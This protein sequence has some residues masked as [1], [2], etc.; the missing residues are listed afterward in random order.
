[1]TTQAHEHVPPP[2]LSLPEELLLMLLNEESGYF[3]QVPGWNL[4]CTFI[5]AVLAELSFR[6]RID[7]DLESLFVLDDTPTGIDTLDPILAEIADEPKRRSTEY[8]I[9]RL[10]ARAEPIIDL[11]LSEL[12]E[13][14]YLRHHEGEFWTRSR[15]V[16][17]A[18]A[19][20]GDGTSGDIVD[21]R[22]QMIILSDAIPEPRDVITIALLN[23][24][25]VLPFIVSFDDDTQQRIE[26]ICE[27]DVIGRSITSAVGSNIARPRVHSALTKNIPRLP[28]RKLLL[29]RY[30][31]SGNIAA[32]FADLASCYGP[33][34]EFRPPLSRQSYVFLAGPE[35][36]RWVHRRGRLFLRSKDYLAKVEAAH[37]TART[38]H[39][40]DGADHFR[41]RSGLRPSH[42]PDTFL[43]RLDEMSSIAHGELSSWSVGDV[44]PAKYAFQRFLNAQMSPLL[45][46]HDSQE[47]FED[48]LIYNRRLLVTHLTGLLPKFLLKM[49]A[50]RRRGKLARQ[51]AES[52]KA[53]HTPAQRTGQPPDVID[54]YFGMHANDEQFLPETDLGFPLDT[55]LL[56]GM[57]L[58]DLTAFTIYHLASNPEVYRRVQAEADALFADGNPSPEQFKQD[59]QQNIDVT[60][61][62]LIEVLRLTPIVNLAMRTVMNTCIVEGYEL[63]LRGKVIIAQTAPH[64]MEETFPD[65]F[66][67]D[68]D[69]YLPPR[70]EHLSPGYAPYGLGTHMCLGIRWTE[71]QVAFNVLLLA[72][73]F[74]FD[75]SPPGSALRT[76]PL[77][78]QSLNKKM[79]FVIKEKRNEIPG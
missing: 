43:R 78:T 14:D 3:H 65:P 44:M 77:P 67:F 76:N 16:W 4:N 9:E 54:G 62:V 1:M 33:V 45:V 29:N 72:H 31:R 15:S 41:F 24:C 73:Y 53:S 60:R 58:A 40:M 63:P 57:Y 18:Q 2:S 25:N 79:K 6:Y 7:S 68:I 64:Y 52:I 30:A 66:T 70:N 36:N 11:V 55:L 56:T 21:T 69:R 71:A 12:V 27:M 59:L 22:I 48:I 42:S 46:S 39:T 61:R 34:F 32:M 8:W 28:F 47:V 13:R 26:F 74:T 5:G 20:S 50:M 51:V 19:S 35:V 49:P 75:L 17:R 10:A 37:G 23:A 38:V